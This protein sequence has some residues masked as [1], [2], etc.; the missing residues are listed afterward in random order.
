MEQFEKEEIGSQITPPS[1][2]GIE[3]SEVEIK[4]SLK[5]LEEL[6]KKESEQ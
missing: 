1:F 4:E 3:F 2:E 5:E 6:I